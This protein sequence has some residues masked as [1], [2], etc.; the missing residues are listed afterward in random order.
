MPNFYGLASDSKGHSLLS[1]GRMHDTVVSTSPR[2]KST[3]A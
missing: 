2:L 3:Y 1:S